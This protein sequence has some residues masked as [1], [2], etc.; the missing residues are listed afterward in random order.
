MLSTRLAGLQKKLALETK[1]RDAAESLSRANASLKGTSKQSSEQLENANRKVDTT[2][3]EL[4]R[5]SEKSGEVNRRLLEHRAGV[6]S[7][8]VRSLEK[9]LAGPDAPNGDISGSSTPN[10]N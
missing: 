9:Q 7:Y 8:S 10:R 1:L 6:L 3:K 5:I 2:Q 4:W